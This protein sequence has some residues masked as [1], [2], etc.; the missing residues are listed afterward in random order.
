MLEQDKIRFVFGPFLTNV[1]KGVEGYARQHNGE[2]LMMGGGTGLHYELGKPGNDYLMRTWNWDA[3]PSGFGT[4]MVD[5]LKKK[6]V[7]KVA[8]L[9]QN[10]SAG[11]V[12]ADIYR[13]AFKKAGI[14]FLENYFEPG[15]KDYSAVLAKISV[16]KP[17]YLLPGY[18]DAVLYDIVQ[19]ATQLGFTK[20]WQVRGSLGPAMKNKDYIDDYVSYVPKYFEEAQ[21]TEPKVKKFIEAYKAYFKTNDFPYDQAPLCSSSCYD[22]VYM[23]VEAMKRAG[24][25][26]DVAKIKQALLSFTYDGMWKI[27]Y[28]ATG[29]EVIDFDIVDVA[30]G[31]KIT[32]THEQPR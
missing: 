17:E 19:Q 18:T 12:E 20:F 29:E 4:L 25:V 13:E 6:G 3:G 16:Q 11:H 28:D 23:L 2:F 5:D 15:T 26:D 32:V 21:K 31:G 27:R 7:K 1:F 24:T 14:E 8:M 10:D 30:K 9:I 22:H